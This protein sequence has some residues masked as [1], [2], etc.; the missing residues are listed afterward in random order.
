MAM[1]RLRSFEDALTGIGVALEAARAERQG[2]AQ[3]ILLTLITSMFDIL[4]TQ[5]MS[6]LTAI[7]TEL[8]GLKKDQ[9][10]IFSQADHIDRLETYTRRQCILIHGVPET[11]A[12]AEEDC[13]QYAVDMFRERLAVSVPLDRIDRAHRLGPVR[14]VGADTR[15]RPIIVKMLR[16]HDK[17]AVFV[18][19]KKLKNSRQVITESLTK[20]RIAILN[21]ARDHFGRERVWTNDGKI[22]IKPDGNPGTKTVTVTTTRELE[23]ATSRW[24]HGSVN[25][26]NINVRRGTQTSTNLLD[27]SNQST[28]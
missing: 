15:P 28:F 9:A 1:E 11:A 3:D 20:M 23:A 4:K 25:T 14:Q 26:R 5:F 21:K 8:E 16:Y 10:T 24:P 17:R 19:K 22:L 27:T 2:G 7:R 18:N 13:M 6:E 12:V